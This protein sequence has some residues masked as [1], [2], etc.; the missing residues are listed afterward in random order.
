VSSTLV[1][2]NTMRLLRISMNRLPT[3]I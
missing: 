1:L 3:S 2:L